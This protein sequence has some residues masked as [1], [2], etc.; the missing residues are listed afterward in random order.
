MTFMAVLMVFGHWIDFYQ[1]IM[2]SVSKDHVTLGWLDFGIG[3]LF[4][5]LMIFFVSKALAKKPLVPKYN[6]FLKESIIHYT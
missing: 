4:V 6:P 5:G 2:G 1:M 3:A